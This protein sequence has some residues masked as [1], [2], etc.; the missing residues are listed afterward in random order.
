MNKNITQ[1]MKIKTKYLKSGTREEVKVKL[2]MI[3]LIQE[4][5]WNVKKVH[6]I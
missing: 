5:K 1:N 2:I 6:L 4:I 3:N